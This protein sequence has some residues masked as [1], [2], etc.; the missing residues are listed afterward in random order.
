MGK[1]I[2]L[3]V[4]AACLFS[5]SSAIAAEQASDTIRSYIQNVQTVLKDDAGEID[6]QDSPARDRLHTLADTIFDFREISR[7]SMGR[8]WNTLSPA[9]QQEYVSLFSAM[10]KNVYLEKFMKYGENPV[11]VL[12]ETSLDSRKVEVHSKVEI[13]WTEIPVDYKMIRQGNS[14]RIY[15]IQTK[16]VSLTLNYRKQFASLMTNRSPEHVIDVLRKKI[17]T[18]ALG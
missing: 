10:L 5:A 8:P 18:E 14:W 2:A 3:L 4:F 7:R 13:A 16:G 11:T 1:C 17:E 12:G 15:D 6:S 9:Q